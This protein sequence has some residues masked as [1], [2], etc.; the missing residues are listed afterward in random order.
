VLVIFEPR[1]YTSRTRLFETPFALAFATADEVVISAAHL[2]QKVP[3]ALRVSEQDLVASINR[4]GG[5]ARFIGTVDEI[6]AEVVKDLRPSDHVLVLS[7]GGFGGIHD[8][9]LA[10]LST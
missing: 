9:L 10:R 6:V 5:R 7:N 8:K 1:S 4:A 2:P 3:P